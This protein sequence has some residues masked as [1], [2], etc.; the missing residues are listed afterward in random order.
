MKENT[1]ESYYHQSLY[2]RYTYSLKK[3]LVSVYFTYGTQTV[4]QLAEEGR[5]R[6]P[7]NGCQTKVLR[8]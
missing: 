6:E 3:N 5:E 7:Y 1:T 2:P 8:G 4:E